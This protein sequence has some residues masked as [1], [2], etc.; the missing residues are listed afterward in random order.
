MQGWSFYLFS[1]LNY[2][3][4]VDVKIHFY[5]YVLLE[6]NIYFLCEVLQPKI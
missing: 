6:H 3:F 2:V 4:N 5:L 1:R